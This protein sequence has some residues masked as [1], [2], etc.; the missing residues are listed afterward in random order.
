M[1]SPSNKKE[2]FATVIMAAGKGTRMKNPDK[3]KVMFE[4]SG[5]PMIHYV[6]DLAYALGAG[7]IVAIV[8][9]QR[10]EVMTYLQQTHPRVEFV[11]QE[12]QLGTGHAV[13][14]TESTLEDFS[15]DLLVLSGDVP[16]LK[17]ETINDMMQ[18]HHS[19]GAVATILTAE[20][21]DP[22]GYGR[23]IRNEDELVEEIVEHRDASS[24][25]LRIKEINSGIYLFTKEKLFEGLHHLAPHNVQNEYYLTD[26]FEYFWRG[27]MTVAAFK[28]PHV[29]EIQ[30]VNT[31]EHLE[32]AH[33]I[34]GARMK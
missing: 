2:N 34:L 22:G 27:H 31:L 19:A 28:A 12:P 14:Q 9:F 3:A 8:G 10:E 15:G 33:E 25:Q 17:K 23:V 6:A 26:V 18:L 4:L 20:V 21:E 11:V 13:M 29:D 7:R 1:R 32:Q 30:G 5:K 24:D 16:L